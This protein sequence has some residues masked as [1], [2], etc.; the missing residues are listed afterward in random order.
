MQLWPL[1]CLV[2]SYTAVKN[3]AVFFMNLPL[4]SLNVSSAVTVVSVIWEAVGWRRR[5]QVL[6]GGRLASL[7]FLQSPCF[8]SMQMPLVWDQAIYFLLFYGELNYEAIRQQNPP[9]WFRGTMTPPKDLSLLIVFRMLNSTLHFSWAWLPQTFA[10]DT[11]TQV[12]YIRPRGIRL[13][14][15]KMR[16][17]HIMYISSCINSKI[18]LQLESYFSLSTSSQRWRGA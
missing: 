8:E 9:T 11:N 18:S 5:L 10:A 14:V 6:L 2:A 7:A 4:L 17:K 15:E 1:L 3:M 16:K 12:E 13:D